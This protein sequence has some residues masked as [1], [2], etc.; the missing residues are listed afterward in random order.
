ME[1]IA[2]F[3]TAGG[4]PTPPITTS[5]ESLIY[6]SYGLNSSVL[7]SSENGWCNLMG[8]GI[9]AVSSVND[10]SVRGNVFSADFDVVTDFYISFGAITGGASTDIQI[11]LF[12]NGEVVEDF[13]VINTAPANV[14]QRP[15]TTF[16]QFRSGRS[17]A[18][19]FSINTEG[20]TAVQ[21]LGWS[22]GVK[23]N[24]LP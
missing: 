5:A 19:R 11:R 18:L 22:I 6:G 2:I 12:E 21:I 7:L 14:K 9:E 23:F 8:G 13:G 20:V 4:N 3:D 15:F 10:D 17:Y 24:S 16:N 1:K